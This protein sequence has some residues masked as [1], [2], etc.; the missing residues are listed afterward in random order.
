MLD[1]HWTRARVNADISGGNTLRIST[2]NV[3]AFRVDVPSGLCLTAS[4]P[5]SHP[6]PTASAHAAGRGRPQATCELPITGS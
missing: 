1:K 3:S 4:M 6:P 2:E 5:Q